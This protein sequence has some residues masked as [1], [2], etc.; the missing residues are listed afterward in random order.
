MADIKNR[1]N[2]IVIFFPIRGYNT[3]LSYTNQIPLTTPIVLNCRL[4]DVAE[5]RARGGQRGGFTKAYDTQIS[6]DS[7]VISMVQ[8]ITTYVSP[9]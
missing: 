7:P 1:D 5:L 2:Y 4:R 8:L 3:S 9:E 6:A